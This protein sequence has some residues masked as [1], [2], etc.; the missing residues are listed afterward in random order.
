MDVL[1]MELKIVQMKKI[2]DP[3]HQWVMEK[4]MVEK[5]W[6]I[7]W[8][9]KDK[10]LPAKK[11]RKIRLENSVIKKPN[12]NK[13][14]GKY[15]IV[16][17]VFLHYAVIWICRSME[18]LLCLWNVH[19]IHRKQRYFV[20]CKRHEGMVHWD[21]QGWYILVYVNNCRFLK[22]QFRIRSR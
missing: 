7:L 18:W 17:I 10:F 21:V 9:L 16:F 5:Y 22:W 20:L 12:E 15:L 13:K 8:V 1:I 14:K 6:R 11:T 2:M 4:I 19:D 3:L